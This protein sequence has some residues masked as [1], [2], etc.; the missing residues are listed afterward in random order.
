MSGVGGL[1]MFTF[2]ET[3][4]PRRTEALL[5]S[6]STML[7]SK[8]LVDGFDSIW[9][10]EVQRV[11][12]RR[13]AEMCVQDGRGINGHLQMSYLAL[14]FS[15][16]LSLSRSRVCRLASG[17][18]RADVS[19]VKLR[20]NFAQAFAS[21]PSRRTARARARPAPRRWAPRHG[22]ASEAAAGSGLTRRSHCKACHAC[23][24]SAKARSARSRTN[25]RRRF[26][27]RPSS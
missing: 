19:G 23:C 1:V 6:V 5:S 4:P 9:D 20:V 8:V 25:S 18:G 27:Q 22:P 3:I 15:L 7:A 13:D 24:G 2:H 14:S 16:L 26:A 17:H 21:P 10:T 12:D 11:E